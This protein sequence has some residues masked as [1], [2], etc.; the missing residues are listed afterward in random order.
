MLRVK[1]KEFDIIINSQYVKA[2]DQVI[3]DVLTA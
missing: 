3:C 2:I 1:V